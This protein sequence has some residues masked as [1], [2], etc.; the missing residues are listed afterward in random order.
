MR[1][2]AKVRC[3]VVHGWKVTDLPSPDV[4]KN[5]LKGGEIKAKSGEKRIIKRQ[6]RGGVSEERRH[7]C[8]KNSNIVRIPNLCV[9]GNVFA[10]EA[11][12]Q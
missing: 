6:G 4:N 12:K 8:L 3:L 2:H 1:D 7:R 10:M 5:R 9:R 11:G